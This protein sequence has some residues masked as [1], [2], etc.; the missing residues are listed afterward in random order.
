ML[1]LFSESHEDLLQLLHSFQ[2]GGCDWVIWKPC[3]SLRHEMQQL[4]VTLSRIHGVFSSALLIAAAKRYVREGEALVDLDSHEVMHVLFEIICVL[5]EELI[6]IQKSELAPK[7]RNSQS[8]RNPIHFAPEGDVGRLGRRIV[9]GLQNRSGGLKSI[10]Q[11]APF[12]PFLFR[13]KQFV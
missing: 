10:R 12:N 6:L 7:S 1:N 13:F 11:V 4:V 8:G 9:S 5:N 2:S 3:L